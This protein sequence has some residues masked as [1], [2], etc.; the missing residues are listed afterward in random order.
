VTVIDPGFGRR[1]ERGY[2]PLIR[3]HR[4]VWERKGLAATHLLLEPA[5]ASGLLASCEP[6]VFNQ[7]HGPTTERIGLCAI[8]WPARP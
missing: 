4:L 6:D 7:W 3:W 2:A 1:E 8:R 5:T